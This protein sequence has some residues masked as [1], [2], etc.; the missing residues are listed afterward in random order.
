MMLNKVSTHLYTLGNNI[1]TRKNSPTNN[2]VFIVN[3]SYTRK[4]CEI[5]SKLTIKT[6]ELRST[7]FAV[8]FEH[9]SHLFL[10]FP[11]VDIKQVSVCWVP[12]Y[13]F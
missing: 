4:R 10:V 8:D 6:R 7:I 11:I 5:H 13:Q 9:I 3:N 1:Y 2:H 12:S